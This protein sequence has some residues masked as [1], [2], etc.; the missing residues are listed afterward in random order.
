VIVAHHPFWIPEKYSH[1]RIIGGERM[2]SNL[3]KKAGVD[4][5]MSGHIHLAYTHIL[6]GMIISHAGTAISNRLEEDYPNSF[7]IIRGDHHNLSV[8]TREWKNNCFVTAENQ[9]FSRSQGE[10]KKHV[11]L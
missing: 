9:F 3:L 10:W 5:I 7:K 1:R 4:I 2:A 6:N 11:A 8:E